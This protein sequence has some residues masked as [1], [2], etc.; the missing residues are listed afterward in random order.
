MWTTARRS[1]ALSAWLL[2]LLSAFTGY[3]PAQARPPSG[4]ELH[5]MYCVEVLRAEIKL[6]QHLISASSEAAGLAPPQSREQWINTS[7][8]LLGRL[9]Q[10]EG[11]LQRLQLFM[12]PRIP[13]IDSIALATAIRQAAAD[14]QESWTSEP[15]LSRA[16]ACEN[17]AWLR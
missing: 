17:P 16:G 1:P 4:D 3:A 15:L 12:L 8:E 9:V 6:Q 10:L 11:A 7:A 5:S 14:V 2:S 13:T